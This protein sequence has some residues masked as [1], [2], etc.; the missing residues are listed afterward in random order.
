MD[1][2]NT[3]T[4]VSKENYDVYMCTYTCLPHAVVCDYILW[5]MD[6]I[7]VHVLHFSEELRTR[8]V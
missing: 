5:C 4:T 7:P 3:S 1:K 8:V 6:S 2:Y